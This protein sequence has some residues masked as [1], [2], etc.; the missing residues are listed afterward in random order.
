MGPAVVIVLMFVVAALSDVGANIRF[1]S[2]IEVLAEGVP[3]GGRFSLFVAC[4]LA[5]LLGWKCPY[6]FVTRA[7]FLPLAGR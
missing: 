2:G 4:L 1:C 3:V 6:S 5:P 7:S